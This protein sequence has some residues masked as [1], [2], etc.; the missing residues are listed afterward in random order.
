MKRV[1]ALLLFS[2]SVCVSAQ[3]GVFLAPEA[4]SRQAFENPQ[5]SLQTL[6]LNRALKDKAAKIL[7]HPFSGLRQRYWGGGNRTAWVFEEIGKEQ[8]ITIGVL[9]ENNRILNIQVLEYRE[10]RG[11]EVRYPFF[12]RQF[13]RLGLIA[14]PEKMTLDGRI[15]GI[16]GATLSVRAITKVATLALYFHHNTPFNH[17]GA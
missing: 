11:G 7:G 12:T 6:W 1:L 17:V 2:F 14:G 3:K 5:K 16:T 15:D 10:S 9:V 13:E 4:F 8:P